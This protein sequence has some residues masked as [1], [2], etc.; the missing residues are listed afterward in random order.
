MKKKKI[1]I[2][3]VLAAAVA[4]LALSVAAAYDS[5]SDPLIS[6]S[7]LRDVFKKELL[8]EIDQK[9]EDFT[10]SQ[11]EEKTEDDFFFPTENE[12]ENDNSSDESSQVSQSYEV[13]ELHMGDA[14]YAV[15]S[16]E[17]ILR[18]GTA[19]CT[20]PDANQGIADLTDGYEIYNGYAFTKNHLCL[21]P[22]GDGRGIIATSESVYLMVRGDY[23]IVEN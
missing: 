1:V 13:I 14:L 7:Y 9:L 23:T 4:G 15:S 10:P 11:T 3:S 19:T 20:A 2:A 12:T 21:I 18:S 5:S 17:L 6:L 8:E 16:C 22:R